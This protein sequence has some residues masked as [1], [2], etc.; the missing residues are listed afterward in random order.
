MMIW[1]CPPLHHLTNFDQSYSAFYMICS[2]KFNKP[3]LVALSI[4]RQVGMQADQRSIQFGH[5]N[6]STTMLPLIQE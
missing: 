5:E 1:L 2:F 3:S 4:A 6:V